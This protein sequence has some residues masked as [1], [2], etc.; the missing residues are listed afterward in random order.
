[1]RITSSAE[2]NCAATV[3]IAAPA[4]PQEKTLT[5]RRSRIV[6]VVAEKIRKYS[7]CVESP[8]ARR[9]P[10]PMLYSSMPEMPQK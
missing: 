4:M 3:A 6:F 7:G 5:K 1:M 10:A 2:R 8:T 9:M